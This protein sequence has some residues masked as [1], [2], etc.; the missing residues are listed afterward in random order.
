MKQSIEVM[1]R[2]VEEH[3]ALQ[4]IQAGIGANSWGNMASRELLEILRHVTYLHS[5]EARDIL[6]ALGEK[7]QKKLH[8]STLN[9]LLELS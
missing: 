2:L 6:D 9:T 1:I 8:A 5:F 3:L 4:A 7:G